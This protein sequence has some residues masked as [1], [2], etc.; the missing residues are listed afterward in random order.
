MKRTLLLITIAFISCQ[1]FAQKEYYDAQ[2]FFSDGT[3]RTGL[4][5][6]FFGGKHL[7][8]KPSKNAAE[9][10]LETSALTGIIYTIDNEPREYHQLKTYLGWGQKRIGDPVW[11]RVV[12]KGI[13]TL[14][15]N[16]TTLSGV[17][18]MNSAGFLDYYCIRPGEGAAKWISAV[19]SLNNNQHFR[20]KAP[21]YF[22]DYPEL[23]MKIKSK[24]YT[25]KDIV[26]V[27]KEY[28]KW[29]AAK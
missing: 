29:A 27:V 17:N 23:S 8:F 5:E 3:S 15:V 25:W 6:S 10:K 14:Y 13:A 24:E 11:L 9:E 12:E 4:A 1:T 19:S 26:D 16:K 20:A 7:F 28:N 18:Q 2:V 22:Q 21:A